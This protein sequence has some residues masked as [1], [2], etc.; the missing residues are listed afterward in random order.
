MTTYNEAIQTA[1]A[2]HA[3]TLRA[4]DSALINMVNERTNLGVT[5]ISMVLN[6]KVASGHVQIDD[7]WVAAKVTLAGTKA[8]VVVDGRKYACGSEKTVAKVY[9][10]KTIHDAASIV[11]DAVHEGLLSEDE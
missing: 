3:L 1:E 9:N 2:T 6:N 10:L 7:N 4:L 11:L 8:L 5:G